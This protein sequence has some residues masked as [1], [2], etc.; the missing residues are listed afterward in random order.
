V[1]KLIKTICS[2][3]GL[4]CEN[5]EEDVNIH[6]CAKCGGRFQDGDEIYCDHHSHTDKD[7]APLFSDCEHYHI[8]CK[9]D[10]VESDFI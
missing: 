3:Q 4:C 1:I 8:L 10:E 7:I 2:E 5:C 9:P 6:K